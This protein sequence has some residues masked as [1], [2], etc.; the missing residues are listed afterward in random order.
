MT[1]TT[2]QLGFIRWKSGPFNKEGGDIFRVSNPEQVVEEL[3]CNFP[4]I[5]HWW[6][7]AKP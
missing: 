2:R 1:S 7:P 6:V 5:K 3:N 4:H